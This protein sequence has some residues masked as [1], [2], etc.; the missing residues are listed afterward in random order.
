MK[1]LISIS[2]FVLLC[3]AQCFATES[4][5]VLWQKGKA[6][7]QQMKY[8]SAAYYFGQIAA[9]KPKNAEVYYN[10][11][12]TYYRL[13]KIAPAVLSYERAIQLNPDYK[14]AKD[15]LALTQGRISNRI[16]STGDIF[17]MDW[18]QHTTHPNKAGAW[19]IAAV[20]TFALIVV[21]LVVRR[22]VKGGDKLPVQVPGI[23]GFVCICLLV[24]AFAASE[25]AEQV[26]TAVV[27]QNDAPLMN[28]EQK[29]KPLALIPEGTT[30][31]IVE[32]KT[33]WVEVTLPDGRNGWLQQ[34]LINKL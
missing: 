9:I 16:Q 13:N 4:Y 20:L 15:N 12:N 27:M 30:V 26:T 23:L 6:S 18:W 2:I 29:G 8:D 33:T 24:L 32:E 7:Y 11:G 28:N 3:A 10:L 21:C 31:K 14:E 5:D 19:A 22:F 34:S 25:R 17:F 1:K